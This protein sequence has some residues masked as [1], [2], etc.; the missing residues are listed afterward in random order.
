MLCY[1]V[2]L[3][4]AAKVYVATEAAIGMGLGLAAGMVWKV[5]ARQGI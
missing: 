3:R 4:S 2:S 1:G 5:R